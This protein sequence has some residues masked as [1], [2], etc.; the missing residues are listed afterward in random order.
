[1]MNV[2]GAGLWS[3]PLFI[4]TGIVGVFATRPAPRNSVRQGC[5]IAFMVLSIIS[6]LFAIAMFFFGISSVSIGAGRSFYYSRGHSYNSSSSTDSPYY[7]Y[8]S[9]SFEAI[10]IVSLLLYFTAFVLFV[11][12][13]AFGC[14]NVCACCRKRA[15]H[16]ATTSS[17]D[18][19]VYQV[20]PAGQQHLNYAA[21]AV[22]PFVTGYGPSDWY[23]QDFLPT[24]EQ[25]SQFREEPPRALAP[26]TDGVLNGHGKI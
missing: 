6:S 15:A 11:V 19:V 14:S 16:P 7:V 5:F 23:D 24:Y 8:Y 13:S 3:A 22:A 9:S 12:T 21:P 10:R 18:C 17:N 20:H 2:V 26:Q 1:M 25:H 4:A